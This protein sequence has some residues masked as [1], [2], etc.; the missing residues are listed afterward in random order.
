MSASK[1]EVVLPGGDL[2]ATIDF[3][4]DQ[5][6]FRLDVIFPADDPAVAVISGHGQRLRLDKHHHGES[7]TLHLLT[8][9]AREPVTAPNG[10]KVIF[11]KRDPW[12][13]VPPG[14][15]RFSLTRAEGNWGEGRAGMLYRDLILDRQDGRYIASH[16]KIPS[17]GPVPDYVHYH[18][19]QFQMIYCKAGWVRLVYE[20]QGDT[21]VLNA[22]DCV[23]QPP[24][25]RH[26]VLESSDGLEV[27]EIGCPAEH[28]THVDHDL[29]LPNP[30]VDPTRNF[31]G[32]RFVRH[33]VAAAEWYEWI[34]P[35]FEARDLGIFDATQGLARVRVARP[36]NRF[37]ADSTYQH[38]ADFLMFFMLRGDAVF[39]SEG[40]GN[41]QIHT[42]DCLTIARDDP[43]SLADI[44][45]DAEILEVSVQ[46]PFTAFTNVS[47]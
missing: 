15:P 36:G 37:A 3:F 5:L 47:A 33:E 44:S 2:D 14:K 9:D 29:P 12:P 32:Q 11:S 28:P 8:D 43:F 13:T 18:K 42:D 46:D 22:G 4:V 30:H 10:T 17:G 31:H 45:T 40:A 20:D 34:L 6:G 23:L 39:T 41:H 25:I 35:G 24:E 7:G 16:I 19:V 27:I 38:Q 21:F 1:I 26:R